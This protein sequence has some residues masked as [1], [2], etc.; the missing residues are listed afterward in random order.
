MNSN[1]EENIMLL[2]DLFPEAREENPDMLKFMATTCFH[3]RQFNFELAKERLENYLS[4]RL[5]EFG[6]LKEF[7]L[8]N[9]PTTTNQLKLGMMRVLPHRLAGGE[10][11]IY[12]DLSRHDA[13][14]FSASDTVKMWHYHIIS[15][16]KADLTL[17]E[18]GFYV[19]SNMSNVS[20][21]NLDIRIPQAIIAAVSNCM[22]IRLLGFFLIHPPLIAQFI[23]PVV[24]LLLSSKLSQRLHIIM[25]TMVLESEH[26]LPMTYLPE[27]IGGRYGISEDI[28]NIQSLLDSG[29]IV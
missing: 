7:S 13:T 26:G 9:N 8:E 20:H 2:C 28:E 27:E 11:I 14:T 10:G 4:W 3:Y 1:V 12:L 29:L 21:N 18:R 15:A 22:P 23:L 16:L 5:R 24:K 19:I 17:A 6:S 25:D